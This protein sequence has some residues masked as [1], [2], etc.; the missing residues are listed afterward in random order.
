MNICEG[1]PQDPTLPPANCQGF[2]IQPSGYRKIP[3]DQ[4]IGGVEPSLQ[5]VTVPCPQPSSSPSATPLPP[6]QS[7]SKTPTPTTTST[8]TST[9]TSTPSS[10]TT[11]T[12]TASATFSPQQTPSPTESES[13]S[14]SKSHSSTR[15]AS[16]SISA[17]PSRSTAPTRI[18]FE[19][20]D[21]IWIDNFSKATQPLLSIDVANNEGNAFSYKAD[22][23][24][25]IL[26]GERD[27]ILSVGEAFGEYTV[28][29]GAENQQFTLISSGNGIGFLSLQYDGN[30]DSPY[31]D[32]F[33][34]LHSDFSS[35]SGFRVNIVANSDCY[36]TIAIYDTFNN[37]AAITLDIYA[38]LPGDYFINF[39]DFDTDTT[40]GGVDLSSVSAVELAINFFEADQEIYISEFTVF[41]SFSPFSP[42]PS[43]STKPLVPSSSSTPSFVKPSAGET[44][45]P[46]PSLV[47]ESSDDEG[48]NLYW[49]IGAIG[50]GVVVIL[51]VFICVCLVIGGVVYYKYVFF[52]FFFLNFGIYPVANRKKSSRNSDN[53]VFGLMMPINDDLL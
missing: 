6:S 29:A 40:T 20:E 4:C 12:S 8:S 16:P 50:G 45:S 31:L 41:R 18:A 7:P 21:A 25:S 34:G 23:D 19:Y 36:G 11:A 35:A 46:I 47:A 51:V 26:G 17:A 28:T 30:D 42:S 38:S 24:L 37:R 52:L 48:S 9:T 43:S 44:I 27:I 5:A 10:S 39:Y 13:R 22:F 2:Y 3:G 14:P 33:S 32:T 53:N 49:L 1:T 15:S